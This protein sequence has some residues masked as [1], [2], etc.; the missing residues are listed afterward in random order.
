MSEAD[1][2]KA[3]QEV[4]MNQ[5]VNEAHQPEAVQPQNVDSQ[6]QNDEN[7]IVD[8]QPSLTDRISQFFRSVWNRLF[9]CKKP[10][11]ENFSPLTRSEYEIE[12]EFRLAYVRMMRSIRGNGIM[13]GDPMGGNS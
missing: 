3:P 1:Y 5:I 13:V 7:Q 9:C 12:K 6:N 2:G 8:F 10:T 4:S 11:D